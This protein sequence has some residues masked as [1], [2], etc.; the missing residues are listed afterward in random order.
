MCFINT[1]SY[2]SSGIA[3]YGK[4]NAVMQ[5]IVVLCV[6]FLSVTTVTIATYLISN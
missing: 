6:N 5:I 1:Y 2:D 3:M 4:Y